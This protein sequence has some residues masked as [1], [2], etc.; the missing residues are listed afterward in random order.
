[1]LVKS[2]IWTFIWSHE[3][4]FFIWY[5]Y[6]S[7][8]SI[9]GVTLWVFF[10][11]MFYLETR[12]PCLSK[13]LLFISDLRVLQRNQIV[14]YTGKESLPAEWIWKNV[15]QQQMSFLVIQLLHGYIFF[16][17]LKKENS[18]IDLL[19]K[20]H[21]VLKEYFM[22]CTLHFMKKLVFPDVLLISWANTYLFFFLWKFFKSDVLGRISFLCLPCVYCLAHK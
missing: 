21:L 13:K 2:G 12:Y 20:E 22:K 15:E 5:L 18:Y 9:Y 19:T 17:A 11:P 4:Y 1:M 7:L 8:K 6:L 3:W 14:M 16:V 10:F